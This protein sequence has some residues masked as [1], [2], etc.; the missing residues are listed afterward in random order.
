MAFREGANKAGPRLLEPI[1]DV[2][3]QCP[4]EYLGDVISNLSS[5]TGNVEGIEDVFGGKVIKARVPLRKM[6]GYVTDL[7]SMTSG[8]AS[9]TMQFGA[10]EPTPKAVQTELVD[11]ISGKVTGGK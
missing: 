2:E 10:Y 7:R 3:V 6:F 5:R 11:R 1:M 8:R 9:N 4:E